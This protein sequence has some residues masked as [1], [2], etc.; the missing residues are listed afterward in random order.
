M[1]DR[2]IKWI[3]SN[4][5]NSLGRCKKICNQMVLEFPELSLVRGHYYCIFWGDRE[6]WWLIDRCGAIIDP[7]AGQFPSKGTGVYATWDES[8]EEPTGKCPNCGGYV[9]GFEHVHERCFDEF[10]SSLDMIGEL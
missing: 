6:H 5:Y 1:D 10:V 7:T 3:H 8:L 4:V 2:Y 9:Y